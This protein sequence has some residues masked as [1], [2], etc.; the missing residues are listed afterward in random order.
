MKKIGGG[1]KRPSSGE[2]TCDE[3]GKKARD[4]DADRRSQSIGSRVLSTT[5][6][7]FFILPTNVVQKTA[8]YQKAQGAE[9]GAGQGASESEERTG[10]L[11]KGEEDVGKDSSS[12][13][14]FL[15]GVIISVLKD[16]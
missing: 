16:V 2:M 4:G 14:E 9:R 12:E 11:S 8:G 10:R 1:Q 5:A 7:L 6:T 13:C 3:I 15:T